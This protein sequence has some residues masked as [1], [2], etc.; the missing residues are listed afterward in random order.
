M[1]CVGGDPLKSDVWLRVFRWIRAAAETVN[2]QEG[3][4]RSAPMSPSLGVINHVMEAS[5]EFDGLEVKEVI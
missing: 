2:R 3:R 4:M 5:C 1:A